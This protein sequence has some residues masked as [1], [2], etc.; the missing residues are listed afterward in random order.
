M[1]SSSTTKPP[2]L[3]RFVSAHPSL[4]TQLHWGS[5]DAVLHPA[6]ILAALQ[7]PQRIR[8]Q[9]RK[10]LQQRRQQVLGQPRRQHA[11]TGQPASLCG[12]R[13]RQRC[14]GG[15]RWQHSRRL[16]RSS[17]CSPPSDGL[18]RVLHLLCGVGAAARA[19]S[20]ALLLPDSGP[21]GQGAPGSGG[22]G[23]AAPG[24]AGCIRRTCTGCC[25]AV[26]AAVLPC[27]CHARQPSQEA[28]LFFETLHHPHVL[29]R[30]PPF[31]QA[32]LYTFFREVH[33]LWVAAGQYAGAA[34][35]A[36]AGRCAH[37]HRRSEV[38]A[39]SGDHM[40]AISADNSRL[41][42]VSASC[43]AQPSC[44]LTPTLQSCGLRMWWAMWWTWPKRTTPTA[45]LQQVRSSCCH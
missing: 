3:Y 38:A 8:Q 11:A 14:S 33:G 15:S 7:V 43:N 18:C 28:L 10:W 31:P 39:I 32:D 42:A 37:L 35:C 17:G 19:G 1:Q 21:G 41:A 22:L 34:R 5:H 44:I 6:L 30:N 23:A 13:R 26:Q 9:Q 29:A 4:R 36:A 2:Q 27:H 16:P 12:L 40:V 24:R 25:C 45:S 20:C